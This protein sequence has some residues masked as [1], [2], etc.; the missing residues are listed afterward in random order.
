MSNFKNI[1]DNY[2]NILRLGL[3]KVNEKK[4][5]ESKDFFSNLIKIDQKRFEGY[6]TLSNILTSYGWEG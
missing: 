1:K 4:Y 6:L 5:D 2:E 3:T